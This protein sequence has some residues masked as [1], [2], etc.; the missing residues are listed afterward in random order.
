VAKE[1]FTRKKPHVNVYN[2]VGIEEMTIVHEGFKA[3]TET[4]DKDET[5]TVHGITNG[6][7][8]GH[9]RFYEGWPAKWYLPDIDSDQSGMAIE[10]A[11]SSE[12]GQVAMNGVSF[13]KMR[14]RRGTITMLDQDL[15][16]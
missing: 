10:R 7:M 16:Y 3:R 6:S 12:F 13:G 1:K 15:S 2:G 8:P 5:I 14:Q 4:V 9:R 11:L